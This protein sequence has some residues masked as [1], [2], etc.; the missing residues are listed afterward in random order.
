MEQKEIIKILMKSITP[1]SVYDVIKNLL[2]A[3]TVREKEAKNDLSAFHDLL[4]RIAKTGEANI[5]NGMA[6][7]AL[8]R[9]LCI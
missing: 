4:T 8:P 9:T 5:R 2:I 1:T 3:G 6:P 7:S